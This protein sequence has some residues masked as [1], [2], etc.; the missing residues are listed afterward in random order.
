ME[1][2]CETSSRSTEADAASTT[3][4]SSSPK[5]NGK[6]SEIHTSTLGGEENGYRDREAVDDNEGFRSEIGDGG[7][8][9]EC[10]CCYNCF[11]GCC[12]CCDDDRESDQD[13]NSNCSVVMSRLAIVWLP[14]GQLLV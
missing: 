6:M 5:D 8:G 4:E 7:N 14:I 2:P 3:D 9:D 13:G 1:D 10:D 11:D 12:D